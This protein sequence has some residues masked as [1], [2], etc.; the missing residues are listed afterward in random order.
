MVKTIILYPD[1]SF[2]EKT[3]KTEEDKLKITKD[4]RPSFQ[5]GKSVFKERPK[6]LLKRLLI[7]WKRQRNLTILVAGSPSA[8]NLEMYDSIDEQGIH[9]LKPALCLNFGTLDDAVK[10]LKKVTLKSIADRKQMSNTQFFV[11][12]LLIVG[13]LAFQFMIMKGVKL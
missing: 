13:V 2:I 10:F 8:T 1:M 7:F 11:L 6:S 9:Q 3:V 12:A 4:Y 5:L